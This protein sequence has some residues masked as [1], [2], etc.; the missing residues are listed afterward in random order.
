MAIITEYNLM[1]IIFSSDVFQVDH[2][3]RDVYKKS[4]YIFN[5]YENASLLSVQELLE[6][7]ERWF[8]LV[9]VPRKTKDTYN[10][11]YAEKRPS[12]HNNKNCQRLNSDYKNFALPESIKEQGKDTIIEFREW[13]KSVEY[14][15]ESDIE[16]FAARLWAK[17]DI[18]TNPK[19]IQRDNSGG[20]EINNIDLSTIESRIDA[21][22]KEAGR[23]FYQS[24]KNTEILKRYGRDTFL[25]RKED[26]YS[27][28][29][30]Y[31]TDEVKEFLKDYDQK[32]KKPL[33]E[34]LVQYYRVKFNPNIEFEGNLLEQLGF[35]LCGSCLKNQD[36][37]SIRFET[38]ENDPKWGSVS[39]AP[40]TD[41]KFVLSPFL[42]H[43]NLF[44]YLV[45]IY[46]PFSNSE[47]AIYRDHVYWGDHFFE[48][49]TPCYDIGLNF[50][51]NLS[52]WSFTG[53]C[54]EKSFWAK[55]HYCQFT[56]DNGPFHP[57]DYINGDVEN[58]WFSYSENF[59]LYLEGSPEKGDYVR[60]ANNI[61]KK[62]DDLKVVNGIESI[63]QI[64]LLLHKQI[65]KFETKTLNS[66][67]HKNEFRLREFLLFNP[68][69][70]EQHFAN[71]ID[72]KF[73]ENANLIRPSWIPKNKHSK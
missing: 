39:Y 17:W 28:L 6:D 33:K 37:K 5:R 59:N 29:K 57:D 2:T 72:K 18:Q 43:P 35:K 44:W 36:S 27:D 51:N 23:Y 65:G 20:I 73:M 1:S 15:Y 32:F 53:E 70:W 62:Y 9:Y 64:T 68:L 41:K 16:A 48:A 42:Q 66:D 49:D 71:I 34:M 60:I 30:N 52:V 63:D 12:Y 8:D 67:V 7:P 40:I 50:N 10:F 25:S 54:F 22:L 56:S 46:Y 47:L 14:L 13:F 38:K 61:E 19:A 3:S 45:S 58:E 69:I 4:I 55:D 26:F 11:V 31:T 24:P 21:K